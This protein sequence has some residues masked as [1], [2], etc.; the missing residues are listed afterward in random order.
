MSGSVCKRGHDISIVG[1][2]KNGTCRE[3]NRASSAAWHAANPE[4]MRAMRAAWQAAN[5]E[6]VRAWNAAWQ[7][8]NPERERASHA[9]RRAANPERERT[10]NANRRARKCA[11]LGR[12]TAEQVADLFAKQR[13][14]C[15][16]CRKSLK[17]AYHIDHIR[18]LVLGG[19]NDISNI[20]LLCPSCNLKKGAKDEI[21]WAQ[22]Q[23][24]LL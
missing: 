17:K 24:R 15:A 7:A 5:P 23:G 4:R 18:A 6:K 22:Q 10:Y 3:C 20:Q 13:C 12:Y 1:R 8:A 14:K 9:A 21:E 19:S 11:A 16:N 2:M